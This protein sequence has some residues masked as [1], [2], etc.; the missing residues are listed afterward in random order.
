MHRLTNLP[1]RLGSAR[2]VLHA[3]SATYAYGPQDPDQGRF[4]EVARIIVS[5]PDGSYH[6]HAQLMGFPV[7]HA[8]EHTVYLRYGHAEHVPEL[9][10]NA[11]QALLKVVAK[12][13]HQFTAVET[14]LNE[15]VSEPPSLWDRLEGS[16]TSR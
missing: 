16:E 3:W 5:K 12:W 14:M 6:V 1:E 11:L 13:A 15:G 10:Q 7:S 2:L 4:V 8:E 9:L